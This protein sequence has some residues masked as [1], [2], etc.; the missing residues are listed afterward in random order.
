MSDV[1][2]GPLSQRL[3][4]LFAADEFAAGFAL[5]RHILRYFPRYIAVYQR[6]G[7]AAQSVG[8]F[9]DSLDLLQRAVSANPEDGEAWRALHLAAAHLDLH[10]D[11]DVAR[12]YAADLDLAR[13]PQGDIARGHAAAAN[14]L[15]ANAYRLYRSGLEQHPERMDA[16]LGLADALFRLGQPDAATA[17]ARYVLQEL[18][19][20]LKAH[21]I[22]LFTSRALHPTDI[23]LSRH[24]RTVR[25][26]DPLGELSREWFSGQDIDDI[27]L[28]EPSLPAWN[29]Q[30]RWAYAR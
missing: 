21:L 1:P 25:G 14:Q 11:A 20:A 27:F 24:L 10:P 13:S 3:N 7:L 18:P 4:D 6:M 5:G 26:L 9:A 15:W 28:E 16:A 30:E 17:I 29:E 19:Y 12:G 22:I 8:L 23:S 2:L